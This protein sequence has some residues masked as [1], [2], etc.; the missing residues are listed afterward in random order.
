MTLALKPGRAIL[1]LIAVTQ[2]F[3]PVWFVPGAEEYGLS[4]FR[5]VLLLTTGVLVITT[6]FRRVSLWPRR[7]LIAGT[8]LAAWMLGSLL[9]SPELQ[10]GVRQLSYVAVIVML[11]YV[12]ET[13]TRNA[14]DFLW[15]SRVIVWLGVGIV[16]F[17]LYELQTGEHLFRSSLQEI[18]EM[19]RSMSYITENQAW[20]TFGNP[21]DLAVHLAFCGFVYAM[22]F[23]RTSVQNVLIFSFFAVVIYI[24]NELDARIVIISLLV[25]AGLSGVASL[26]R[27]MLANAYLTGLALLSGFL[28]LVMAL[29]FVDR[30]EFLD[31]ST[32][33]RLKLVA[34][35]IEMALR[36]LLVGIGAGAFESEMWFSGFVGE[37]YG[38]V[39]PHNAMGRMLAENGALGLALLGYLLLGP[40]IALGRS[41]RSTRFSAFV[42]G[43]SVGLLLLFSVGSDPLS[44]S[45]LQLAI[46]FMWVACRF[47]VEQGEE[48]A[49][50]AAPDPA[51]IPRRLYARLGSST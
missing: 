32:F 13:L 19:D 30:A 26:Q 16:L 1:L 46:A 3:S 43:A 10:E 14:N 7:A 45:S 12:V 37:T 29:M 28:L 5:V 49:K 9:W 21:N 18:A 44:S 40:V 17:S 38:I 50:Q 2:I 27:Q 22:M 31:V 42:A 33:I 35:S 23:N 41:G 8:L 4:M 11:I 39:N 36:T 48:R 6:G 25:F 34:S 47:A 15:F 20:F 51:L 24:S